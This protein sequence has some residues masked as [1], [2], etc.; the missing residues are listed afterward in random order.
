MQW[1]GMC[2]RMP[3]HF[4]PQRVQSQWSLEG[5]KIEVS[6]KGV[7]ETFWSGHHQIPMFVGLA[8]MVGGTL[9]ILPL[10]ILFLNLVTDVFPALALGLGAGAD[11][12]MRRKPRDPA[13]PVLVRADWQA[14]A[15]YGVAFTLAVIGALEVAQRGLGLPEQ[16]AVTISFLTLAF[17]QLWHVFNMRETG[18]SALR[19]EVTR[20][21]YVWAALALCSGLTLAAVYIPPI[22]AALK[23]APPGLAGWGVVLGMSLVPL[24]AGQARH[25]LRARVS[26]HPTS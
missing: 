22:A 6:L 4:Y 3:D 21:P 24:V 10:Q 7:H 25:A 11:N 26:V 17:A 1:I 20:N 2:S 16:E 15:F 14:I 8:A 12:L 18:T 9:P 23:V 19:N 5:N 13:E